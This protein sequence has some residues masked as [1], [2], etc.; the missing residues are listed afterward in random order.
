MIL[1]FGAKFAISTYRYLQV[2]R[3]YWQNRIFILLAT[4]ILAMHKSEIA[5][6]LPNKITEILRKCV[7]L[8][9]TL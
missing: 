6:N 4:F 5:W 1:R 8:S 7:N 9:S 2:Q 3:K